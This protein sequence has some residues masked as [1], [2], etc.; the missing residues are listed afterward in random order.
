MAEQKTGEDI[1]KEAVIR[2]LALNYGQ[3]E[4]IIELLVGIIGSNGGDRQA[5][6]KHIHDRQKEL[7][8][9]FVQMLENSKNE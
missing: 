5:I 6:I 8:E 4:V 7:R 1:F 3:N 9:L 2:A